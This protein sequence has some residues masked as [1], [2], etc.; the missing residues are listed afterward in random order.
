VKELGAGLRQERN[1]VRRER[2]V[3]VNI[4][5]AGRATTSCPQTDRG[6][7]R[8][9][10]ETSVYLD[11]G[12]PWVLQV[13]SSASEDGTGALVPERRNAFIAKVTFW[14]ELR[15]GYTPGVRGGSHDAK[16]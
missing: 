14:A 6:R 13:Y 4:L 1:E 3:C 8:R 12:R 15:F 16:I 5:S 2:G 11:P 9:W 10:M 7:R